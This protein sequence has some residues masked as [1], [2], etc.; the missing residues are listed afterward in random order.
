MF[1]PL[2]D[3]PLELALDI[4]RLAAS[5]NVN[6]QYQSRRQVYQTATSLA[7]VSFGVRQAVMPHL[8]HTVILHDQNSVN[9]FVRSIEQ[10]KVLA[11]A[12][13]RLSLDYSQHVRRLWSNRC[14]TPLVH[15]PQ[16]R[17]TNYHHLFDIFCRSEAL[18][19]TFDSIHLIYEALGGAQ[20]RPHTLSE[21]NCRQ[22]T[23]AGQYPRWNTLSS[24]S[25]GAAFLQRIT[26]L[27][28]WVPY[29]DTIDP[30]DIS[31]AGHVP[32]WI[33]KVPFELMPNLL[34]FAFSLATPPGATATRILAYTLP[35]SSAQSS[36]IF[37]TWA[38]S[39]NPL[40]YGRFFNLDVDHSPPELKW[41]MA[42]LRN[43]NDLR[44][45]IGR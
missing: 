6:Q 40:S 29:D 18:G 34:H 30:A 21:W 32:N 33:N 24:T 4:L 23:F 14:H 39:S 28:I 13:S 9:L 43:T 2:S 45:E 3:L 42:F 31:P 26:H 20:F 16:D 35:T 22:V 15:W 5:T 37:R 44:V 7:Y 10:Q 17:Y 11:S 1:F 27:T 12:A 19:F 38:G 41:E 36:I 25:A 8:L